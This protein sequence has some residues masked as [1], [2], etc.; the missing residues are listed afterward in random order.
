[1]NITTNTVR[2]ELKGY[3]DII[4]EHSFGVVRNLLSYLAETSPFP[5]DSLVIEPADADE[6][7]MIEEGMREYEKD[8]SSFTNWIT[9]KEE[10]G[11]V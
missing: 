11:I 4:P 9:V 8:P 1:M 5:N 3:I 6:I 10:M 2:Q 7:A